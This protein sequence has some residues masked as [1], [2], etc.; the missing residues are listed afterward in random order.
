MSPTYEYVCEKCQIAIEEFFPASNIPDTIECPACK[1]AAQRQITTGT[2][3]I[4]KGTGWARDQYTGDSNKLNVDLS[5]KKRFK[6]K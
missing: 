4:L 2:G 1:T 6:K 3:F 5:N